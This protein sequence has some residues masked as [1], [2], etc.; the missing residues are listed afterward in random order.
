M[1]FGLLDGLEEDDLTYKKHQ[2]YETNC[3]YPVSALGRLLLPLE[4]AGRNVALKTNLISDAALSPNLGVEVGLAPK[5]SLD[6]SGRMNLWTINNHKWKHWLVQPEARY[7]FCRRFAVPFP[8]HRGT[9]RP[10]QRR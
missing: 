4:G 5:W 10:I 8:R 7:W 9:R 6:I 1:P 2:T 3:L